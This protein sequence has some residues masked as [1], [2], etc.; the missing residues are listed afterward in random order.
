M[1]PFLDLSAA[2]REL[3]PQIDDAVARVLQSGWYI[4]GPEVEAFEAE[5][6]A[7]C[8]TSFAVGLANGLDA[9]TL[10]LRALDIGPGDR[11]SAEK[12]LSD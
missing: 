7:Y 9:L 8:G 10:A 2:Y 5:W 1:I 6:A 3:K 12:T 4:L 11:S